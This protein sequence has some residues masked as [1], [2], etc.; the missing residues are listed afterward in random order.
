MQYNGLHAI[1]NQNRLEVRLVSSDRNDCLIWNMIQQDRYKK[2]H[3]RKKEWGCEE[4]Y[5]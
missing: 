2:M 5:K 4:L 1:K 3:E